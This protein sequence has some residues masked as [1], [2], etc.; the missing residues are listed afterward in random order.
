MK[1]RV[2]LKDAKLFFSFRKKRKVSRRIVVER[3]DFGSFPFI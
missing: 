1:F 2:S 3:T